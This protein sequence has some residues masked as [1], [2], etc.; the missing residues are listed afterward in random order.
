MVDEG[1]GPGEDNSDGHSKHEEVGDDTDNEDNNFV[2]S[3]GDST[4]VGNSGVVDED[5]A[6]CHQHV[7]AV[8]SSTSLAVN[9][10]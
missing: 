6:A 1:G 2:D 4:S 7:S 3:N 5:K 9:N 8:T 10:T